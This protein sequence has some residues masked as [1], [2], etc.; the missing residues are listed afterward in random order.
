MKL[1]YILLGCLSLGLGALGVALPFYYLQD[2]V[3]Q[4]VPNGYI[5]GL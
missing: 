1:I 2:F 4:K 3:L 5:H